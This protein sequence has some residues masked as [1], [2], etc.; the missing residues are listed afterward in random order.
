MRAKYAILTVA[1]LFGLSL[2]A[3][4]NTEAFKVSSDIN[5]TGMVILGSWALANFAY[6]GYDWATNTGNRKYFGQM[7][8]MW[9]VVNLSIAGFA[10]YQNYTADYSS[11]TPE[12]MLKE[13]HQT[14]NLYLL[15]AGLDVLYAAGGWYLI[16]ASA[17]NS[18][19]T[20]MLKG[21]G[22]SVILQA[23][24]LFTFDIAMYIIQRSISPNFSFPS[25]TFAINPHSISFIFVF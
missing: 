14:M 9:N 8:V 12:S 6:G 3:Q 7:N 16:H 23:S 18:K 21:Y 24:F 20:N 17:K 5:R 13:H 4:D 1:L 10:L 19:Y 25:H 15:N 2:A 11:L 22:Q